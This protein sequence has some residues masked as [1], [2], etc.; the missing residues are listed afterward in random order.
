MNELVWLG[1]R[2]I[3]ISRVLRWEWVT[4]VPPHKYL[5][6]YYE[7]ARPIRLEDEEADRLW[8]YLTEQREATYRL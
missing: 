5:A 8:W 1:D 3:N 6:G 4:L 7:H 2:V